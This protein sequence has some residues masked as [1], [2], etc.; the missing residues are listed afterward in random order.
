MKLCKKCNQEK[1]KSE[2][3]SVLHKNG[4]R[5]LC[6]PC[7]E[8]ARKVYLQYNK[9]NEQSRKE[10]RKNYLEV[11]KQNNK[12]KYQ[13]SD[14]FR[15]IIKIRN[16]LN[17]LAKHGHMSQSMKEY[18]GTDFDGF[19]SHIQNQLTEDMTWENRGKNTWHFDHIVS[20]SSANNIE[21]LQSLMHYS[22]IR[23]L[24]AKENMGRR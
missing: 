21:E 20:L 13:S 8:C 2:F 11:K 16:D 1:N 23:P 5:Y 15:M 4:N 3:R 10:L 22:N 18:F 7:K 14:L 12:L 24:P 19:K 17:K 6:S 9:Q